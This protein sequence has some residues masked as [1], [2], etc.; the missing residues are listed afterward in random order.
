M[1][2]KILTK[3]RA[4]TTLRRMPAQLEARQKRRKASR[5]AKRGTLEYRYSQFFT[6]PQT[7]GWHQEEDTP[8]FDRTSPLKWVPS[9]TTYGINEA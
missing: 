4:S 1:K 2:K 8:I 5:T 9:E 6:P 7:R 3:K